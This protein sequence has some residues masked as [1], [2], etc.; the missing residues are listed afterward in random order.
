MF[1]PIRKAAKMSLAIVPFQS[2]LRGVITRKFVARWHHARVKIVTDWQA[3]TRR[4][5]SNKHLRPILLQEQLAAI[6]I[7]RIIRGKIGRVKAYIKRGHIAA[8]RIQCMWRG[9][10]ARVRTDMMWLQGTV[11]PIQCM[12]RRFLAIKNALSGRGELD[13]A[14]TVIQS[15]YRCW[16]ARRRVATFLQDREMDYREDTIVA[17]MAEEEYAQESLARVAA[18]LAKG[19]LKK[20]LDLEMKEL[21][22][23]YSEI[24]ALENDY[25]ETLR[26]REILSP[27]AIQQGWVKELDVS[28]IEYR[29][30]ITKMKLHCIFGHCYKVAMLEREVERKVENVLEQAFAKNRSSTF[31]EEE[32]AD[33]RERFYDREM[34]TLAKKKRMAIAE[35]R[36]KWKVLFYTKDGKPDKK[37]RP[38]K[39]WDPSVYAKPDKATYSSGGNIDLFAFNSTEEGGMPVGKPGSDESVKDA[40]SK[41]ALQT[42]LEQMNTYEQILNPIQEILQK[43]MGKPPAEHG[44]PPPMRPEH[45]GFG[46]LGAEIPKALSDIGAIPS[47]WGHSE[48]DPFA[49]YNEDHAEEERIKKRLARK[50]ALVLAPVQAR[51][52]KNRLPKR[53]LMALTNGG[54]GDGDG[55]KQSSSQ[56]L[57]L[58]GK[59]GAST[60]ADG[61]PKTIRDRFGN[62]RTLPVLKEVN[63]KRMQRLRERRKSPAVIPWKLL[64]ELEGEK[65]RFEN[66]VAYVEF[67]YKY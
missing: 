62:I 56:A 48:K 6:E 1:R 26:Q 27:R 50:T 46:S 41:V 55:G 47:N 30:R 5:Y 13:E 65:K 57:V 31:R 38:G 20:E 9:V 49:D 29:D 52:S 14:A 17:L 59:P 37:R 19:S 7:Q 39:P 24:Y 45:L 53:E 67:N 34:R 4:F 15:C 44:K 35:E 8:A 36:R 16:V 33:R 58:H 18:R 25:I 23:K 3:R 11:I 10:I 40:L 64:D 60:S 61:K 32:Y 12:V 43:T 28:A 22:T 63:V 21:F 2:L 42:Y 51:K 66:E 54:V